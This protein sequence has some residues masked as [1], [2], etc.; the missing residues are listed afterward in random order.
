ME[1]FHQYTPEDAIF[2]NLQESAL[3]AGII[4][5]Q[6]IAHLSELASE[7]VRGT[8]EAPLSDTSVFEFLPRHFFK[9]QD[10]S[11][12]NA[13]LIKKALTSRSVWLDIV[14]CREIQKKIKEKRAFSPDD[15]FLETDELSF[16]VQDTV[17][18]QKSS[19][20]DAAFLRFSTLL[21][22]PRTHYTSGFPSAC[23][24]VFNGR[25]EF[26]IL[27]LENSSEGIL[28]SFLRLI[29][30]FEL[31][32]CATCDITSTDHSRSTKFALLRR[33]LTPFQLNMGEK[34]YFELSSYY[35]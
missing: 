4:C 33:T 14:L 10:T 21:K 8:D 11:P 27:P 35:F 3:R 12:S 30:R 23:E 32:I 5:E 9:M 13:S 18:Y 19:Y 17:A 20:A 6:E 31:H 22:N 16:D 34:Q 15:F 25:C 1:R 26:C 2:A 7:L 29:D 24:D 28:N